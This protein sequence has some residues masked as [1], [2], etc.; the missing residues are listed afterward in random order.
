MYII[1]LPMA[2]HHNPLR[3]AV[4]SPYA[5]LHTALVKVLIGSKRTYDKIR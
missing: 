4:S 2:I 5:Y 3:A 1:D